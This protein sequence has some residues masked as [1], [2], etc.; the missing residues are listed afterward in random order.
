MTE[1][2]AVV[3]FLNPELVA[4]EPTVLR[5]LHKCGLQGVTGGVKENFLF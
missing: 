1:Y 5:R 4:R 3:L 2:C